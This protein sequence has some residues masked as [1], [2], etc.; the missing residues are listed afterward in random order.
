MTDILHLI[1]I[2]I[3]LPFFLQVTVMVKKATFDAQWT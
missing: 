1:L 2:S 3:T